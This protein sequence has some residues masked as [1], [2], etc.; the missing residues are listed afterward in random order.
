MSMG[1][2]IMSI[3]GGGKTNGELFCTGFEMTNHDNRLIWSLGG[4]T[5]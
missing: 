5:I 3:R 1:T 4:A 2:I